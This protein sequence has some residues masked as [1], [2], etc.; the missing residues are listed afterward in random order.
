MPFIQSA[1]R[2]KP[3][4]FHGRSGGVSLE[5]LVRLVN[6]QDGGVFDPEDIAVLMRA[7]LRRVI[8]ALGQC[9]PKQRRNSCPKNIEPP[10]SG[11]WQTG[12]LEKGTFPSL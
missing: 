2:H 1:I 11:N 6:E 7:P 5:T 3:G 4:T 8:F 12:P 10:G 9:R